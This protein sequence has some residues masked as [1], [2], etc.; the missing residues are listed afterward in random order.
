MIRSWDGERCDPR[1]A[2]WVLAGA[3]TLVLVAIS[4]SGQTAVP[5]ANTDIAALSGR[6]GERLESAVVVEDHRDLVPGTIPGIAAL[7]AEGQQAERAGQD[8]DGN[9][10]R[11]RLGVKSF[12]P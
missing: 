10:N 3:I 4:G 6:S 11:Q 12:G 2:G 1:D 8:H 9:G 5:P 7:E